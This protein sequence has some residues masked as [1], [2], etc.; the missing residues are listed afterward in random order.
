[1]GSTALIYATMF[2]KEEIVLLLLAHGADP[3]I[4][5]AKGQTALYHAKLQGM[6]AVIE[7]LEK[8]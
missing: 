1:M 3:H 2:K 7:L 8:A 6:T 4:K 5:D